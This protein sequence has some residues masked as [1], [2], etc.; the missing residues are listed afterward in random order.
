MSSSPTTIE[1]LTCKCNSCT[2][3]EI[4]RDSIICKTCGATF[5]ASVKV[6]THDKLHWEKHD[7]R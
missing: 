1:L 2:H 6:D 4:G 3:W 5:S 7:P